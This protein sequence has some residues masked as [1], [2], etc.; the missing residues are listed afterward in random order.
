MIQAKL[1]LF[2]YRF[3]LRKPLRF[4][5]FDLQDRQSQVIRAGDARGHT[6]WGEAAPLPG[7]HPEGFEQMV[8]ASGRLPTSLDVPEGGAAEVLHHLV[9]SAD[10]QWPPS[11]RYGLS[12]AIIS[13]VAA[14]K[15]QT[16]AQYLNPHAA[17]KIRV[18][19]LLS[20]TANDPE[21]QIREMVNRGFRSIKVK[22]GRGQLA[23]DIRRVQQIASVMPGE[24]SLRL[25]ANRAW[26]LDDALRF[27]DQI[28]GLPVE[29]L[30]EPLADPAALP[31]LCAETGCRVAL[32][33]SLAEQGS[34]FPVF[35]G[36]AAIVIKPSLIGSPAE[37]FSLVERARAAS[38]QVVF[39]GTFE[40]D[41][42]HLLCAELAAAWGSAGTA[43]GLDTLGWV[44]S[45]LLQ[46]PL[47]IRNGEIDLRPFRR[48]QLQIDDSALHPL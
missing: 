35:P 9:A 20:S 29:Y 34:N 26:G 25:D 39:S 43:H 24:V 37:V 45:T 28:R 30:E 27:A 33:E 32:D 4:M 18:N 10:Q 12:L 38:L 36:L 14:R 48:G 40:S 6:G 7:L 47:N 17:D 31:P 23:E 5:G 46:P 41:L 1:T 22:V 44:D 21:Q 13:L 3:R 2:R 16:P 11:L 42:G 8:E 15:R 19:A